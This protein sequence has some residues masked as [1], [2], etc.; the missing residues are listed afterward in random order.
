MD[1]WWGWR[2]T[3]WWPR[4]LTLGGLTLSLDRQAVSEWSR[5]WATWLVSE[6]PIYTAIRAGSVSSQSRGDTQEA[7]SPQRTP[8]GRRRGPRQPGCGQGVCWARLPGRMGRSGSQEAGESSRSHSRGRHLEGLSAE[9]A[10]GTGLEELWARQEMREA[11]KPAALGAG[12]QAAC[13]LT[14]TE[15]TRTPPSRWLPGH[16]KL[17]DPAAQGPPQA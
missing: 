6:A 2:A 4:A 8:V 14:I 10:L 7:A 11:G 16:Q 13:S 15:P 17:G 3:V 12:G 9:P 1:P 5:L